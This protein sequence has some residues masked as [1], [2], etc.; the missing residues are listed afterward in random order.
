MGSQ[1]IIANKGD[2][3]GRLVIIKEVEPWKYKTYK[4]RR[5]LC[6]CDCGNTTIASFHQLRYGRVHSCGCY[7]DEFASKIGKA[8]LKYDKSA[9]SSKLYSIWHGMKCRCNTRSSGSF[10][11][12]GA[13]GVTVCSEW[14]NDFTV[15]YNWA[16]SNGYS[17]GLTID[18]IDYNGI[19]EPSNC[20]WISAA[21]QANNRSTNVRI[22]HNGE[23][24]TLSEWGRILGINRQ[25][26]YSRKRKGWSDEK[27]LSLSIK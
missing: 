20:R 12:Y 23:E 2:R 14:N 25:T 4:Y 19:Y 15:F 8:R 11:R 1:K 5:V 27:I 7:R 6:Q 22:N 18:R 10:E 13:K 3:F 24:H 16:I 17:N 9:T 21:E 26:L